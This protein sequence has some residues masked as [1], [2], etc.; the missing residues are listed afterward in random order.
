MPEC[1]GFDRPALADRLAQ[2]NVDL[3]LNLSTTQ[4]NQ[5]L[6]FL[7]LLCKWNAV[8]NLTAIRNPD[9]MLIRHILD[10]LA[11]VAVVR[12]LAPKSLLDVGSGAGLP[13]IPIAIALPEV[14]VTLVD[15]V[16]KKIA[17]QLQVRG[18]LGL[19]IHSIHTRVEALTFNE[20]F[21]CVISRAFSDLEDLVS[22]SAERV[23]PGGVLVAMK[24]QSP[25]AEIEHLPRD[26]RVREV[27]NLTVP[28]LNAPRCAV[29]LERAANVGPS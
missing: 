23:A 7:F 9:E 27:V 11:A 18:E 24:A 4:R 21:D 28:G 22:S 2:S 6:D 17:F 16:R 10:S 13:G 29:I 25:L 3:G 20:T 1:E 26:W 14:A 19:S 5:L 12:R 15:A 8:Y